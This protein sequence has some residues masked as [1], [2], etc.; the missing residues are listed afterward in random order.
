MINNIIERIKEMSEIQFINI[1]L[2]H[3]TF[4]SI[5]TTLLS[6]ERNLYIKLDVYIMYFW[7]RH[8]LN[9]SIV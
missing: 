4:G 2:S 3:W 6:K 9:F 5:S 7:E 1:Y 8:I